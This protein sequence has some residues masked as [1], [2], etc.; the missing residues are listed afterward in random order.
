M[1]AIP[2]PALLPLIPVQRDQSRADSER[3]EYCHVSGLISHGSVLV[4][5]RMLNSIPAQLKMLSRICVAHTWPAKYELEK[6][7][8]PVGGKKRTNRKNERFCAD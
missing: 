2:L 5:L 7:Q 8:N 4:Q 3:L 6:S 1:A